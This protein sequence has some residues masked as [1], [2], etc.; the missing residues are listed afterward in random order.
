MVVPQGMAYATL[1]KLPPVYGLYSCFFP[2]FF[3]MFFGTSPHVSIGTFAVASMMVGN[4]RSQLIPENGN[5][6]NTNTLIFEGE[7]LTPLVLI[8]ALTFGVGIFQV[9]KINLN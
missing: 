9:F 1:A 7:P 2:A 4:L 6:N 5:N 3:Y 8:S